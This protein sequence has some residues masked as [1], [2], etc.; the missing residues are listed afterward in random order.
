MKPGDL[1]TLKLEYRQRDPG[2]NYLI[3][4][5]ILFEGDPRY[6]GYPSLLVLA[7]GELRNMLVPQTANSYEV[8]SEG[9]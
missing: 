4:E 8:V 7:D 2:R 6:L 3:V 9:G 5:E 1:I